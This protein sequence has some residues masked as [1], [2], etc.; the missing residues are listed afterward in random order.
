MLVV[1]STMVATAEIR[2][3]AVWGEQQRA[4]GLGADAF[5]RALPAL[6]AGF[7]STAV[8]GTLVLDDTVSLTRLGD[9]VALVSVT[10]RSRLGQEAYVSIARAGTD[11]A[12]ATWL[13]VPHRGRV[14]YRPIP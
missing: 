1:V 2:A 10:A 8:G 12:G 6:E 14:R 9:S 4:S 11:S 7:D 3:G 13:R 5:A